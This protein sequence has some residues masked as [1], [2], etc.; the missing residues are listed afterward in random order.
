MSTTGEST[1]GLGEVYREHQGFVR[2][3]LRRF[4]VPDGSLDDAVQDVFVAMLGRAGDSFDRA[5]RVRPW[6]FGISRN[7]A[8]NARR[9]SA[10]RSALDAE[11][12]PVARDEAS[13]ED[14]V[15]RREAALLLAEFLR[16]LDPDKLAPFV[17]V[18]I[19]G[20]S[21]KDVA[22][23]LGLS[24]TTVRWRVRSA[25][26]QLEALAAARSPRRGTALLVW[27]WPWRSARL[28]P[29]VTWALA[30]LS[31]A[32]WAMLGQRGG[33]PSPVSPP[34]RSRAG[35]KLSGL[36]PAARPGPTKSGVG[37]IEVRTA[38]VAGRVVDTAGAAIAGARVC[39]FVDELSRTALEDSVPAC[40]ISVHDGTYRLAGVRPGTHRVGAS[41]PDHEPAIFAGANGTGQLH[42]QARGQY[43]GVDIVLRPG[44][45]EVSG[46]VVDETGGVVAGA[47]VQGKDFRRLAERWAAV[48]ISDENGRFALWVAAGSV[49]VQAG[50]AGYASG[51]VTA[52]APETD[53]RVALMPQSVLHG[54]VVDDTGMPVAG[55]AVQANRDDH[56]APEQHLFATTDS[57]G[58]FTLQR[59]SAGT[60][61][62]I[63]SGERLYGEAT[64]AVLIAFGRPAPPVT[65]VVQP[66][67][68]LRVAIN[69]DPALGGCE[70]EFV[71][72][73]G[74]ARYN[75]RISHETA[76]FQSVRPG[77]YQ[78][79]G[80]CR[81]SEALATVDVDAGDNSAVLQFEAAASVRGRLAPS[82]A[83]GPFFGLRV[84]PAGSRHEG[85]MVPTGTVL[86]RADA[87][88]AF[89]VVL[90]GA[91]AYDV[92]ADVDAG[93]VV[94]LAT[95]EVEDGG[96]HDLGELAMPPLG[97]VEGRIVDI[98]GAPVAGL[99]IADWKTAGLRARSRADGTFSMPHVLPGRY[100]LQ[101]RQATLK[102]GAPLPTDVVAGATTAVTISVPRLSG[103]VR[104]LVLG[105]G[106]E[107]VV[108]A[109]VG[110][111]TVS[112]DPSHDRRFR[113]VASGQTDDEGRFAQT[114]LKPGRYEVAVVGESV[115]GDAG[116]PCQGAV[117]AT[118][119][120][121]HPTSVTLTCR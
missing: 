115:P 113:T 11:R 99:H 83:L 121:E 57:A 74:N 14:A 46:T 52:S 95:F 47:I 73:G 97:A 87:D 108:D 7:V 49:T 55:L 37:L 3:C 20:Q 91:G 80:Q 32:V 44:G 33:G 51:Q 60:Y 85:S 71:M 10:R 15:A 93:G 19:E 116:M 111:H 68:V 70:G 96:H 5:R 107:P 75:A 26:A 17:L 102:L 50:A 112:D 119:D 84:S 64:Q 118:V 77:H 59:L 101:A 63:A 28:V 89:V 53:V 109:R 25:R 56:N 58:R 90:P 117:V 12:Q 1:P 4:R 30:A 94:P 103:E 45:A 48:G 72:A 39:D 8:M 42:A 31:I 100:E 24:L 18:D 35:A 67:G 98:D 120:G 6:L 69:S 92:L 62:P 54:V 86:A 104:G 43:G 22:G 82:K 13:P 38:T 29:Q 66:A 110:F 78:L 27:L 81:G 79:W 114:Q 106:G 36:L 2:T 23:A 65:I 88:G 76:L 9:R 41:A 61:R 105:A 16:R 21:A 34:P 40:T